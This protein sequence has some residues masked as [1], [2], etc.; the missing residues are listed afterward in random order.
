M[1]VLKLRKNNTI[2]CGTKYSIRSQD[3]PLETKETRQKR[4]FFS[5]YTAQQMLI[6]H[7]A[8]FWLYNYHDYRSE[9]K[10]NSSFKHKNV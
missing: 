10:K 2:F 9:T 1:R 3:R 8:F 7:V 6:V 5:Q 4:I